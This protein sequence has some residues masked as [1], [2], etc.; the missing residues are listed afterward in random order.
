MTKWQKWIKNELYYLDF[1][2]YNI[3]EMEFVQEDSNVARE[4]LEEALS[5]EPI[6]E[7]GTITNYVVQS[8]SLVHTSFFSPSYNCMTKTPKFC[9]YFNQSQHS[10]A[11]DIAELCYRI[12]H[13]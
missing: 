6:P 12:S 3:V 7:Q 11:F 13:T 2:T 8:L 4:S 10:S 9:F 1:N 5:S